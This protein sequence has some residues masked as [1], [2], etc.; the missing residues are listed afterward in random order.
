MMMSKWEM[1]D[2]D[3]KEVLDLLSAYI[4]Y[5]LSS[6][7]RRMLDAH[8]S[9]CQPCKVYLESLNYTVKLS[10]RLEKQESYE[11]PKDVRVKLRSFLKEKCK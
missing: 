3:C 5:E 4:D 11:M 7:E 9:Q 2:C 6:E 8:L 10:V 1:G